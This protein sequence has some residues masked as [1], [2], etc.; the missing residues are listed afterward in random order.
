MLAVELAPFFDILVICPENPPAMSVRL[1]SQNI[2]HRT[3]RLHPLSKSPGALL[4]YIIFFIPEVFT[5]YAFF[6]RYRPDLVHGNGS[7]Q[8]KAIIAARMAGV[9]SLW[10]MNDSS[11]PKPVRYLFKLF[12]GLPAGY[13]HASQRTKNY[14]EQLSTEVAMKT[15]WIIPAPV[16]VRRFRKTSR[17]K[18]AN[19]RFKVLSV[20]FINENKG[21]EYLIEAASIITKRY[22]G[23]VQFEIA[24]KVLA[25]KKKYY[26]KLQQLV[27]LHRLENITFLGHRT[28]LPQL[29]SDTDL[30]VC[31]SNKESSPMSVWEA[32]ACEC[33]VLSTD[34]GDVRGVLEKYKCGWVVPTGDPAAMAE[35]MDLLINDKDGLAAAGE[36]AR[37]AAEELFSLDVVVG[38]YV[39][40][41]NSIL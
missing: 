5:L 13:L 29:L 16:D 23:L 41:Y 24:G 27:V 25:T 40:A 20:G 1:A 28:D 21:F 30:Y 7:W 8:V 4:K 14:Y 35:Q 39:H 17:L 31:A 3:F 15:S 36:N 2:A 18:H 32:L 10:H 38:S 12:S 22:P 6:K 9:K 33:P 19:P 26:H 11:Q 37:R 34:V